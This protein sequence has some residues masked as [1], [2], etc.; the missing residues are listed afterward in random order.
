MLHTESDLKTAGRSAAPGTAPGPLDELLRADQPQRPR[1]RTRRV[2]LV[3]TALV[4]VLVGGGVLAAARLQGNLDRNIERFGDPFAAIPAASRPAAAPAGAMNI[5]LL[6]SDSRVSAGDPSQWT[7]GAQRTDAIMVLHVPADRGAAYV[8]SIPRDS[9]VPIPG[10]GTAKINAAFSFGGPSLMVRTVEQLTKVRIDH[11]VIADFEGF[12][13]LTDAVGGVTITVPKAT[14]DERISLQAGKQQMDGE[15]ALKYVRQRH[16][17]PGGD[18]DRVK[19]QQNWIRA[20]ARQAMSAGTLTNPLRLNRALDALTRSVA[21]DSGFSIGEMRDL[22]LSMRSVR[23]NDLTFMTAPIAGT[24][25][26]A[27]HTQAIVLL[28][29]PAGRGLWKA[30][31]ADRTAGWVRD[32]RDAVTGTSVR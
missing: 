15:T 24:G 2:L 1:R 26:N 32:N 4:L 7:A 20:V 17:L 19:R 23:S 8:T 30:M 5:L 27:D 11:V 18:F 14:H 13:K 16:N 10:H 3:L 31:A 28:D 9:W 22:A 12:T 25:W 21:T 6:G 29:K